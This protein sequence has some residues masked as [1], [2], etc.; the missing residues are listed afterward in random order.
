M[1]Q[2][3]KLFNPLKIKSIE[4]KNRIWVSPMCQ[5]SS[6]NGHP[7]DW[8]FVH[9]GSRAVGGAGLVMVEATAVSPEGRISP[10]DSGI[11]S[12]DHIA[13]FKRLTDFIKERDSVAGIQ[14]AH[15]GRK[16]STAVPWAGNKVLGESEGG[17]QT[18]APSPIPFKEGDPAPHEMDQNDIAKVISDF[19]NAAERALKAGFQVLE[20][21]MAHGYLMHEFLSP[22]SNQRQDQY[23]G[24]LENRMRL[25]L[26]IASAVRKKWPAD[27]PL[28]VRISATDWAEGPAELNEVNGKPEHEPKSW[29]LS[30]SVILSQKLKEA[31]I[32]LIDCSSGG[33]LPTAQIP[34]GPGYQVPF[35]EAIRKEVNIMT[36]AVGMITEPV[37][38]E[39]ILQQQQADAVFL[40]REFLRNPYWP[41]H[42]AQSLGVK[43]QRPV[44][45]ARA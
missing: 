41:F 19:E 23:G 33:N 37:Q 38:A 4:F 28:F 36:A 39:T 40:A 42:A 45:Y 12:D 43:L 3:T 17:W 9:L 30:E 25:P 21:H 27:L 44:Q 29:K 26:E 18:V 10:D 6:S 35:A 24:S 34:M 31:G 13:S 16:A 22:V 14:I 15:A 1:T 7:T 32:D 5:Y 11:W 8:H 2:E 20:I